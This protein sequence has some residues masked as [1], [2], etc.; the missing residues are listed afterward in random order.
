[1]P[2]DHVLYVNDIIPNAAR[3]NLRYHNLK[4]SIAS[5]STQ[6]GILNFFYWQGGLKFT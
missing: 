2:Y 5:F 3:E 1:M 6:D 4:C